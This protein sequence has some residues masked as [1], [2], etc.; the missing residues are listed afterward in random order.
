MTLVRMANS[1]FEKDKI[2]LVLFVVLMTLPLKRIVFDCCMPMKCD[3]RSYARGNT[4]FQTQPV[5][6]TTK[7]FE[8]MQKRIEVDELNGDRS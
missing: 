7:A 5:E 4:A 6:I 1:W 2:M 3:S 8:A